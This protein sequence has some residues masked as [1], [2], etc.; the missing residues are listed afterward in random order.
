MQVAQQVGGRTLRFLLENILAHGVADAFLRRAGLAYFV[1][2][3]D[4][5]AELGAYGRA[6]LA[7]F[8]A[9][10]GLFKGGNHYAVGK[11]A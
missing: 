3:D 7:G 5:P 10:D 2:L 11:P 9:A 8:E 4:V 6:D 1:Q